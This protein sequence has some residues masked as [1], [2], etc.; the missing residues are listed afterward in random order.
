MEGGKKGIEG[1]REGSWFVVQ[2][3]CSV[4]IHL[5]SLWNTAFFF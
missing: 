1:G 3:V 4:R 2:C 5:P